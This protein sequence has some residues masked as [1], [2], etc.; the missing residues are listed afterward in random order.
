[1]N[2]ITKAAAVLAAIAL[3]VLGLGTPSQAGGARS[4]TWVGVD[5]AHDVSAYDCKPGPCHWKDT[6]ADASADMVRQVVTYRHDS[7]R[8]TVTLRKV[9]RSAAFALSSI[10]K[11]TELGGR[12]YGVIAQFSPG[13]TPTV[14]IRN[15][16]G[17]PVDC[18]AATPRISGDK[19]KVVVPA[20][21]LHSPDWVRWSGY[22]R[23]I[24]TG[25]LDDDA[26]FEGYFDKFRSSS[27]TPLNKN[28][29]E[30]SRRVYRAA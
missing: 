20:R 24:F 12:Y 16:H 26:T 17:T 29:F 1:M 28:T 27:D 10:L 22:M 23:V 9:D 5:P 6:P 30:F 25:D 7:I 3:A 18:G 19:I 13:R 8:I 15:P 21:C 4:T 14:V 11:K 2:A